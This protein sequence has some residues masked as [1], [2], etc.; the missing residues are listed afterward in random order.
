[1]PGDCAAGRVP[2]ATSIRPAKSALV[3]FMGRTLPET[4]FVYSGPNQIKGGAVKHPVS[5]VALCIASLFLGAALQKYYDARRYAGPATVA[6]TPQPGA[7][8]P[9]VDNSLPSRISVDLAGEPLFAYGFDTPAPPGDN[10][11]PQNPPN[12]NLLKDEDPVEQTR[13]RRVDGS[14]ASYSLVDVRDGADVI[15]WVPGD[16]PPMSNLIVHGPTRAAE[17]KRG[18]GSCHLPN[19]QGRP[20]NAPV[21]GLPVTY[22]TRQLNDFRH[23]LR[24]TADPRKPHT[25]TMIQL[26]K[27]MTDEEVESAAGYFSSLKWQP[28]TRLGETA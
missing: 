8:G 4:Q 15:D 22:I 17:T 3:V 10:A 11:A 28:W 5:V 18:C 14:A 16:H 19:G 23:G 13:P 12:R 27:A 9:A 20:E 2:S 7:A 21:A 26:A 1:M 25:N 6:L 24:Y